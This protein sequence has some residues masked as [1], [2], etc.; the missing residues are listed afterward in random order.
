MRLN[1]H[2]LILFGCVLVAIAG[3]AAGL[4]EPWKTLLEISGSIGAV[5]KAGLTDPEH[6]K[7]SNG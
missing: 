4:P 1:R 6:F 5:L 7:G 3:H 2:H